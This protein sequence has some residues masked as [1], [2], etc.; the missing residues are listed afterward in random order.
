MVCDDVDTHQAD[1]HVLCCCCCCCCSAPSDPKVAQVWYDNLAKA[2][3][4]GCGHVRLML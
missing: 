1:M 3:Y 4:Q 2:E